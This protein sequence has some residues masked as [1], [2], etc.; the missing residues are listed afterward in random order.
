[1]FFQAELA[2][3]TQPLQ[4]NQTAPNALGTVRNKLICLLFTHR[5]VEQFIVD[6]CKKPYHLREVVAPGPVRLGIGEQ[7]KN[8]GF[9]GLFVL[10]QF[11]SN[12]AISGYYKNTLV[13]LI[14]TTMT[15]NNIIAYGLI[16][17]H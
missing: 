8:T 15:N 17:T 14:L 6:I 4:V 1:M 2:I 5:V 12:T 7:C 3:R 9:P 10:Q 11:V 16:I 13:E